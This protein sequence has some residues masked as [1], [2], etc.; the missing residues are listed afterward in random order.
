MPA[1]IAFANLPALIKIAAFFLGWLLLWLPIAI[2]LGRFLQWHPFR[3][4]TSASQKLPLVASLYV[5]APAVLWGAARLEN[6]SFSVYGLVW[7]SDTLRSL[8]LG[9][10]LGVLGLLTLFGIQCGLGWQKFRSSMLAPLPSSPSP[11]PLPEPSPEPGLEPSDHQ[12]AESLDRPTFSLKS[13]LNL[14]LTT[15]V[16]A[17]W[18]SLTEELIFRGFLLNQ[19]GQDY[20]LVWAAAIAS[21]I[22]AVLHLV[23]EG[24]ENIPQLPGLWLMGVVLCLARWANDGSLGLASGLHAGWVWVIACLDTTRALEIT[25]KAPEWLTGIGGKPLAGLMGLLFLL[26]TALVLWGVA[27]AGGA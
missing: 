6:Q 10:G 16:L 17:L 24:R 5:L 13:L 1:F 15:L 14:V 2:P 18:I 4:G 19:L 23:W 20:A 12:I 27:G 3:E 8:F 25:G 9:W 26:I 7:S 11:K 21:L 22:F